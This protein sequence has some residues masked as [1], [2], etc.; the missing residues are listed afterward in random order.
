MLSFEAYNNYKLFLEKNS[1]AVYESTLLF[2]GKKDSQD[3]SKDELMKNAKDDVERCVAVIMGKYKFFGEF[4]YKLRFLYTY[5]VNTMATDGK[6]I[7]INPKFCASLTDAQI[8]FILC[9]EI[10]HN[11]MTHFIR[12]KNYNVTD[13]D[14]WNRAAD[15][16][17]NP[18]LVDE[19]LLT[20][21]EVK[22]DIKGLLDEKWE[23]MT[24]EAIY[25]Q[26]GAGDNPQDGDMT[27]PAE[28]GDFVKSKD[29]KYGQI[30]S[31][32][33]DGTFEIKEVTVEEVRKGLKGA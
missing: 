24:A 4:V 20:A 12:E 9:H 29:G 31:I 3:D 28:V 23:D 19:G 25:D 22:N 1:I 14:K 5:R 15:Y 27:Y 6:N 17:I 16:E 2:E 32:N 13:H 33:G 7:F 11:V 26:L 18:M 30:E 21:S 8:I 10:L